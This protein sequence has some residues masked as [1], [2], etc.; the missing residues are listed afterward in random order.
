[1]GRVFRSVV[2]EIAADSTMGKVFAHTRNSDEATT[3]N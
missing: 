1:M 3:Q 2:G